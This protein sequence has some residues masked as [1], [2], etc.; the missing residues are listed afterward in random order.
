MRN[1]PEP[2]VA[3]HARVIAVARLA[4]R[5]MNVQVPPNLSDDNYPFLLRAGLNDWGGI[6]PLTKDFINPEKPW[7]HIEQL[8]ARTADEGFELTERLAVYPE[9][10][11]SDEFIDP[12]LI[13]RVR[14]MSDE[15]G[16]AKAT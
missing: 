5:D 9:F 8:A 10:A 12:D 1:H 15:R 16:Y 13:A 11:R 14:S 7:P 2:T 4:L 3:D 6:S